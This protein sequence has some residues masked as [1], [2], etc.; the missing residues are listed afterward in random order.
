M[1]GAAEGLTKNLS[2]LQGCRKGFFYGVSEAWPGL[3]AA[4]PHLPRRSPVPPEQDLRVRQPQLAERRCLPV[5]LLQRLEL[6]QAQGSRSLLPKRLVESGGGEASPLRLA[7]A[8]PRGRSALGT[9]MRRPRC[10]PPAQD[11]LPGWG[12]TARWRRRC[13]AAAAAGSSAASRL[14]SPS[15]PGAPH[16]CLGC[17]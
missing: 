17:C 7:P 1:Q 12:L 2:F 9:P 16:R 10:S 5:A 13:P 15:P 14:P 8:T 11:P 4:V 6:R 3:D